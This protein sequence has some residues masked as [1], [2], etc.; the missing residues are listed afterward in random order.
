MWQLNQV[1]DDL[2]V[3]AKGSSLRDEVAEEAANLA[4]SAS[5]GNANRFLVNTLLDGGGQ[6]ATEVLQRFGSDRFH[7]NSL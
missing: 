6:V 1:Q 3:R 5:D 4:S 2:L 7:A